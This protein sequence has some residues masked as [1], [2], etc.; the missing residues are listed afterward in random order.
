MIYVI[1][2]IYF[3]QI[4]TD[5]FW[6]VFIGSC[7]QIVSVTLLYFVPESPRYLLS[8]GRFE[9][10]RQAFEQIAKLNRVPFEWDETLFTTS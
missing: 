3:W 8:A 2:V 9:D 10:A 6:F 5:W 4:S 7:Y 1:A